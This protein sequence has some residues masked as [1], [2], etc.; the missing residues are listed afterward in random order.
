[1]RT[2]VL[3]AGSW[4]TTL[5]IVLAENGHEVSLWDHD[6]ERAAVVARLRE[7]PAFLPGVHISDGVAVTGQ[8]GTAVRGAA[9]VT[10]VV[11]THV[12]RATARAVRECGALADDA[13]IVSASKGLEEKTLARMSD[14]L[15]DELAVDARRIVAL[16]G[17][18]HAE[19]V[20]RGIPTSVVAAARSE[21][22]AA[23][24]SAPSALSAR[25][26]ERR[27]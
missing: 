19:E 27:R 13:I 9:I 4:G 24:V 5:A 8:L 6:A 3:G 16:A 20:S 7:T 18:G 11:P 12:M 25:V 21:T 15:R 17:P 26:F 10:F 22:R 2:C 23:A 14:V 1:M